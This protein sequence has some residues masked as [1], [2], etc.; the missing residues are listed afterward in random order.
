MTLYNNFFKKTTKPSHLLPVISINVIYLRIFSFFVM[1][2]IYDA[3][4]V[5]QGNSFC[6]PIIHAEDVIVSGHC[7]IYSWT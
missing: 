4:R 5:T 3:K 6:I 2:C 1:L 7:V